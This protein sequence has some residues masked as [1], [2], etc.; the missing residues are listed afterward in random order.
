M[1]DER[2]QV[3]KPLTIRAGFNTTEELI[4][5][6]ITHIKPDFQRDPSHCT[7][8]IW[9]MDRSVRDGPRGKVARLAARDEIALSRPRSS[10]RT[11]LCRSSS[12]PRS[13]TTRRCRPS[14]SA[15]PTCN[16]SND[17]RSE[18][19]MNVTLTGTSVSSYRHGWRGHLNPSWPS[20]LTRPRRTSTISLWN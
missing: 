3:W 8:E 18:T 11:V 15:R 19:A 20:T 13:S 6:Y 17:S 10:T 9:G 2:F 7:V 1:D 16:F 14:S 5:G 4:S 12:R